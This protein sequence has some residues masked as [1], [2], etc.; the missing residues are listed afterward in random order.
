MQKMILL[1][2]IIFLSGCSTLNPIDPKEHGAI[3]MSVWEPNLVSI[4]I[5]DS[6][7]DWSKPEHGKKEEIKKLTNELTSTMKLVDRA[8]SPDNDSLV[9]NLGYSKVFIPLNE[10]SPE[11]KLIVLSDEK[12]Y[13]FEGD[14]EKTKAVIKWAENEGL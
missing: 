6:I 5:G 13:L 1:I 11:T 8:F 12:Y 9:L 2:S 7:I 4:K 10:K 3:Q 14:N